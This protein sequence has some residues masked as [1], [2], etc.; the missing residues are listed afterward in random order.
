[1]HRH[2]FTWILIISG[3][4]MVRC[5][6]GTWNGVWLQTLHWTL[7]HKRRGW[8]Y[9]YTLQFKCSPICLPLWYDSRF[10]YTYLCNVVYVINNICEYQFLPCHNSLKLSRDLS[11]SL[12]IPAV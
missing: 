11:T 3:L 1:M 2:L 5:G 4:I 8:L 12:T 7:Y 6:T 9:S 10:I